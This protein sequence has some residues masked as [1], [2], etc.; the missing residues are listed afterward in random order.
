MS[1]CVLLTGLDAGCFISRSDGFAWPAAVFQFLSMTVFHYYHFVSFYIE[2][3]FH[4]FQ[5]VLRA[6]LD[7]VAASITSVGVDN[8]KE[9]A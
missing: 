5:Y 6:D 2:L 4:E 7:A 3:V 1:N 8:D 9:F